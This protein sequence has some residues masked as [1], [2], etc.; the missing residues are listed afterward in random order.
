LA[1]GA[2]LRAVATDSALEMH[3]MMK[4]HTALFF[5]FSA[6]IAASACEGTPT[7]APTTTATAQVTGAVGPTAKPTK[8]EGDRR[9]RHAGKRDRRRG[10]PAMMVKVALKKLELT[11]EQRSTLEALHEPPSNERSA[12]RKAAQKAMAD[13]VRAGTVDV[14]ALAKT[15]LGPSSHEAM[16]ERLNKLHATLTVEQRAELVAKMKDGKAAKRGDAKRPGPDGEG[17]GRRDEG[18]GKDDDGRGRRGGRRGSALAKILKGVELSDDQRAKIEA[19]LA[20][21]K[22]QGKV[23]DDDSKANKKEQHEALLEAFVG[24]AFDAASVL[25]APPDRAGGHRRHLERLAV[26]VPLLDEAQRNQLAERLERVRGRRGGKRG[27]PPED[28]NP[29]G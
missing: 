29:E 21:A 5:G 10:G 2:K 8:P 7:P 15:A 26:I 12:D 14:D 4:S 9:G 11:D 25:P 17:R 16:V 1:T 28:A 3:T 18:A 27:G 13:A 19:A 6:L 23:E 24:E 22:L 20:D